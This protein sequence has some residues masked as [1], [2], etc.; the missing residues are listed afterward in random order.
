MDLHSILNFF[1]ANK[2]NT[3]ICRDFYLF[4][5]ERNYHIEEKLSGSEI[6]SAWQSFSEYF[7]FDRNMYPKNYPTPEKYEDEIDEIKLF[8]QKNNIS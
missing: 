1:I 6:I 7:L 4:L 3:K 5:S 2:D 8:I